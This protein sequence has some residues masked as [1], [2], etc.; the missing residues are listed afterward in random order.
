[1]VILILK[2][3][4]L[5]YFEIR[6]LTE[7]NYSSCGFYYHSKYGS[8]YS[9]KGDSSRNYNLNHVND[10]GTIIGVLWKKKKGEIFFYQN[11]K[12]LGVAFEGLD[13]KM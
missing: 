9:E 10:K 11:K 3:C 12:N 5:F 7:T 2:K 4:K 1:L 13:K 6:K 8:L